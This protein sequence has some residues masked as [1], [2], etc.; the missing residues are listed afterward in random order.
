MGTDPTSVAAVQ[1]APEMGDVPGNRQRALD[2]VGAAAHAGAQVVVLPELAT[3]GYCFRN[4]DEAR[5]LAEPL[6]GPT[7]AALH[8]SAAE[9]DVVVAAGLAVLEADGTLRNSAVLVDADGLRTTYHKVHLW[10]REPE[11]FTPGDAPP[12]VVDTRHGR[13]GLLVCYDLEFPEWVR[14]LALDG[15]EL[16]C[17]PVN[18]PDPGRPAGERPLEVVTAQ[19]AAATNRVFLAV[20]DRVGEE[21]GTSWVGGS[22]I[23]G[24]EGYPLALSPLDGRT[25]V[26][27][28]DCDLAEARDKAVGPL[29]DRFVDRRPHLY[30]FPGE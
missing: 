9:H 30:G 23:A 24:P 16:V 20:A 27:L 2:A 1:L 22:V 28:A 15:A 6:D 25:A 4:A 7:I 10:A 26:L 29:N 12:T 18:W 8:E 3:T 21:R 19:V 17:A 11:F 13:L 5:A 14:R